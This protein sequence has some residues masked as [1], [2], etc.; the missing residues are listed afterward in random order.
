MPVRLLTAALATL[1]LC[2]AAVAAAAP[3]AAPVDIEIAIDTTGSMGQAIRQ[4]QRDAQKL[5][6]AVRAAV[7]GAR[8]GVVQFKDAGETPEYE[9]LRPMTTDPAAI[10]DALGRLVAGG[11][12]DNPEAYNAV[13]RNSYADKATGW[14]TDSR[15]I[16]IV[17]GDAEPHG[18]GAAGFSGCLDASADPHDLRTKRELAGM[19]A[20]GRTL[21]MVRQ[22]STATV[23]LQCY[24]SL[25]RAAYTGG[26][27]RDL[28]GDL[29]G[30]IESLVTRAVGSP[31]RAPAPRPQ[32]QASGDA[33][34]TAPKVQALPSGGARG[35]NIRLLYRVT[36]AGGRSSE[37]VAV[38]SGSRVLTKSGWVQFGPATGKIYYFDFP[39]PSSM[40]GT[41]RFCV[42]S[43]DPAGNVSPLSCNTVQVL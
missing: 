25:A 19:R 18:A 38:Y 37:R 6:V 5:V 33:D 42:Q 2:V 28:G 23:A 36:D 13:F 24:Q 40:S 7:P 17:I 27:A 22:A 29:P 21:I 34:R 12:G 16:V 30:L 10:A 43:R 1:A 26:A 39:A 35:T 20:A 11:G 8:F 4:A 31:A 15:K 9:L 41:Y 14:R 32:P 3:R